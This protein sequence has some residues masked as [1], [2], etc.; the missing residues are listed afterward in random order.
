MRRKQ[1]DYSNETSEDEYAKYYAEK[2][3]GTSPS[4]AL[5]FQPVRVESYGS[6]NDSSFVHVERASSNN[7]FIQ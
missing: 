7:T 2:R 4:M 1:S 6:S 5:E 3:T